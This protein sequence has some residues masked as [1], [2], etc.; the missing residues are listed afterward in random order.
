[1][2][3]DELSEKLSHFPEVKKH[4]EGIF[5]ADN[6]PKKIK[7]NCFI[8]CNTDI[9]SGAG[10]HWYCVIKFG[11]NILEC[12]DS[13]GINSEKKIFL[14]SHLNQRDITKINFNV[15]QVQSSESDTCGQFVLYFVI[16]RYHNKD[17]SF[18]ELMNEIFVLDRNENEKLVNT[19]ALEH[20]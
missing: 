2:N 10:K 7:K 15:T 3:S 16:Q 13:L 14:A 1:M 5:C 12:F 18:N 6:L 4:F 9:R 20:F 17:L 8:I 19:F 11:N